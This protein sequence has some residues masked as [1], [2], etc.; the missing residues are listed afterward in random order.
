MSQ[1]QTGQF[2]SLAG[3]RQLEE[4]FARRERFCGEMERRLEVPRYV[5][6]PAEGPLHKQNVGDTERIIS[7]AA[8]AGLA[9]VGLL[10]GRWDG[11]LL[12]AAGAALVWRGYTGRC[13]C[14]AALGIDTAPR[15]AA[16]AVPARQG[17]KVEVSITITRSPAELYEFW[18]HLENLPRVMKHIKKVTSIDP[19]RSHWVANGP[20]GKELEWDAEILNE[21]ENELIAWRSL[22]G[23]DIE[24]AGSIHFNPSMQEGATRVTLSMKYNPPAG[25][26]GARIADWIGD[27]LEQKLEE[28]LQRFK[29]V[30][31]TGSA[32]AAST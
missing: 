24:T 23:G 4:D 9:M 18:R 16:T 2:G 13:Q 3:A 14:Y 31:E 20:L 26:V 19:L 30:M 11:L 17:E 6:Q 22:P 1:H 12:S 27:G 25:K 32:Q 28:D 5:G 21:R 7:V 29:H 15:K 8:G 10:R